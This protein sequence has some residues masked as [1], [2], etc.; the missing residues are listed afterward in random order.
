MF[1]TY[2]QILLHVVFATKERQKLIPKDGVQRFWEYITEI[3]S[4]IQVDVVA[5][6]GTRDHLHLLLKIPATVSLADVVRVIK[7]NSSKWA[8]EQG[9]RFAWQEGYA[10]F[11]VSA[12]VVPILKA[13]I[14][15]QEE[16][17]RRRDF[18]QELAVFLRKHGVEYEERYL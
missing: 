16:H 4:G 10:A 11:S 15:R 13:Y 14:G 3:G 2:T 17:H 7:A 6:G 5:I 1:H 8:N 18:R 9:W 12:S